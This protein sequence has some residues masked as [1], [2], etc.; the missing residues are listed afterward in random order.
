M[1][2]VKE[3]CDDIET[4]M[5]RENGQF[6]CSDHVTGAKSCELQCDFG[7]ILTEGNNGALCGPPTGNTWSNE[8]TARRLFTGEFAECKSKIIP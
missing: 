4:T 5:T 7:Y 8:W 1:I 6:K 2:S 3:K